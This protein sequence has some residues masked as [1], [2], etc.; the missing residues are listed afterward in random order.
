MCGLP[1]GQAPDRQ[2]DLP[3]LLAEQAGIDPDTPGD[4]ELVDQPFDM[5]LFLQHTRWGRAIRATA[6]D[7]EAATQAGI[8]VRRMYSFTFGLG[9]AAAAVA[10]ALIG[11]TFGFTPAIGLAWTLKSL[12]I[13]VLAGTGSILGAFPAGLLL[14][15]VEAVSGMTIGAEY[16]EVVGLALFV[17]SRIGS[18]FLL[19]GGQ[20]TVR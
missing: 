17:L 2:Q 18:P 12:I 5:A 11:L 14:G 3:V 6:E 16:R 8:N 1:A 19:Y 15:L 4:I 7:W 13:V 20:L 9:A 10:G